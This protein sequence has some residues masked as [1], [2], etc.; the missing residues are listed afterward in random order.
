MTCKRP[1]VDSVFA[2]QP[3]A[4]CNVNCCAKRLGNE[5]AGLAMLRSIPVLGLVLDLQH[6]RPPANACIRWGSTAPCG[7][8]I[9]VRTLLHTSTVKV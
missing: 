9:A 8:G 6:R 3:T 1:C 4:P 5:M 2:I 7:P